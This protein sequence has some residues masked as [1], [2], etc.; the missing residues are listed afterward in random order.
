MKINI[1]GVIIPNDYK[2][3]YDLFGID[4]ITPNDLNAKLEEASG[5]DVEVLINSSGGDVFSGSEMY[6][7]LMSYKGNVVTKVVGVA[8]SAASLPAMAGKPAMISPTA[9]IMVHNVS[10]GAQGDYRELGH[11][12]EMAKNYNKSIANAYMLKSGMGQKDLLRMMDNETWLTAQQALEY[13]LVDEI[14]FDDGSQSRLVANIGMTQM[15][16]QQVIDKLRNEL[17][18]GKVFDPEKLKA[19]MQGQPI[20]ENQSADPPPAP[21]STKEQQPDNSALLSL[22]AKKVQMNKNRR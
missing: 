14:M 10:R 17:V 16:P 21:P 8:A 4:N 11:A 20:I 18:A 12:A 5:A 6:T 7:S 19:A 9:Q 13:G 15:I 22:Y 3:V 1:K 2:W